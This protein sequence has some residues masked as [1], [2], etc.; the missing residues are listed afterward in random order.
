MFPSQYTALVFAVSLVAVQFPSL[1]RCVCD[2][3]KSQP[4][5]GP[6]TDQYIQLGGIAPTVSAYCVVSFFLRFIK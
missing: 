6:D 3:T 1:S 2:R 4:Q 5:S